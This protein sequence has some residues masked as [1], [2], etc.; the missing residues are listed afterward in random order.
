MSFKLEKLEKNPD[1]Y[2]KTLT[3]NQLVKLLKKLSDAYYNSEEL[4]SDE[5]YDLVRDYLSETDPKNPYLSEV[6]AP[7]KGKKVDLPFQMSSLDKIKPET[8]SKPNEKSVEKWKNKYHGNYIVSDKLDGASLQLYKNKNGEIKI[9]SRGDGNVG[10]DITSKI[11]LLIKDIDFGKIPNDT[12]IRGELMMTKK[13]FKLISKD[14]ANI[15]S[16]MSGLIN[17]N[18]KTIDSKIKKLAKLADFVTYSILHPRMKVS[19][20]LKKLDK[21]GF[22]TVKHIVRKDI[23][24][25]FLEKYFEKRLEESE[26]E[27]DGLVCVDNSEAYTISK[28]NP[29]H[30]FAFKMKLNNL[31]ATTTVKEVEWN[32]KSDGYLAPR[33]VIE[34]VWFNGSKHDFATGKNAKYIV[35]NLIGPGAVIQVV[36]SG[37]IILNVDS[38]IKHAKKPQMPNEKYHWDINNVNIIADDLE[39]NEDVQ[40]DMLFKFYKKIGVANF[41]MGMIKKLYENGFKTLEDIVTA[42]VK[43]LE[44]ISGLGKKSVGKFY[45]EMKN[46]F[47]TVN[48][49]DFM[50]ASGCFSRDSESKTNLGSTKIN[51]ILKMYPNILTVKWTKQ[52]M[53]DK[54]LKVS[55]FSSL[56]VDRFIEKLP[57]FKKFY[58]RMN[59]IFNISRFKKNEKVDDK[60]KSDELEGKT[61]VLTGFRG[62]KIQD[63][64]ES[65]GGKISN[66]VSKKTTLVIYK[67]GEEG[68]GKYKKASELNV[69]LI[70]QSEFMK[71]M[72]L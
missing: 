43:E 19:E 27:L 46:A 16:A 60:K 5:I 37:G 55:G 38:V 6:G 63:Y 59:K 2:I 7:I 51:E 58:E 35:D 12:S 33:I 67:D 53:K 72:K 4:V 22:K 11:E 21:M 48:L 29:A 49:A 30:A 52:E 24:D 13:N 69:A 62:G 56:S 40:I 10:G 18:M 50:A 47:N 71:K 14:Y 3:T 23:N 15:R 70:S 68:S 1:E 34:R 64:I 61:F 44:N 20:Q 36:K 57:E 26:Y 45:H 41:G 54:L 25:N 65:R 8:Q 28:K 32:A 9:Y 42:D 66:S 39:N 31:I 17:P